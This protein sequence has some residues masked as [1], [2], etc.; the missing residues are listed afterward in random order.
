MVD[1]GLRKLVFVDRGS[2]YFEPR[3][4]ETGWRSDDRV[5]IVKGLMPG[6]R[7]V[8][9]GNFLLDS[10]SRMKAAAMGIVTA[11]MDP[12]CGMEVDHTRAKAG[13]RTSRASRGRATPSA[14]SRA[15]SASTRTPE[16]FVPA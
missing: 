3:R 13:G 7:I 5:E 12:V 11:E 4:V 9:S 8:V 10:E 15:S 14:R 6:E 16:R 2:G 1:S